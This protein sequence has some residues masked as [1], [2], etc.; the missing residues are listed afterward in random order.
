MATSLISDVFSQGYKS[1]LWE[2]QDKLVDGFEEGDLQFA[3]MLSEKGLLSL[4]VSE[5]LRIMHNDVFLS[6]KCRY[7]MQHVYEAIGEDESKYKRVLEMLS[8]FPH[9]ELVI[10]NYKLNQLRRRTSGNKCENDYQWLG[11]EDLRP[12][13]LILSKYAHKWED[14]ARALLNVPNKIHHI[15]REGSNDLNKCLHKTL[16]AWLSQGSNLP[17]IKSLKEALRSSVIQLPKVADNL[18]EQLKK[19]RQ[20]KGSPCDSD[21]GSD[22][23]DLSCNHN[24]LILGPQNVIELDRKSSILLEL[25]DFAKPNEPIQYKWYKNGN[26]IIKKAYLRILCVK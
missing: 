13:Y 22:N 11:D 18:E 16:E 10:N 14:M 8:I 20:S 25:D 1:A 17:T 15:E 6:R 19:Y 21:I 12:L 23:M 5:N 2:F 3:S 4:E 9:G 7:V 24:P 26:P